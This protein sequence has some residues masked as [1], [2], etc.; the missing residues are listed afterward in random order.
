MKKITLFICLFF[1]GISVSAQCISVD[2]YPFGDIPSINDG[3]LQEIATCN[4]A[5][6]YSQIINLIIGN[7]YQFTGTGGAGNY[8]TITD[9]SDNVIASGLSPLTV[10]AINVTTVKFHIF[11]DNTCTTDSDCHTTTI[12]CVSASCVP[13]PPPVND[14]CVN[15]VSLTVDSTFCDGTNTNATNAGATDSMVT[16]AACFN[17]GENDVWFSFTVPSGVATVDIS[18]D[19]TGGTLMDSEI[20]L[21]SGNCGAL[22]ELDCDQDSGTTVLSN[23]FTWNSIISDTAVNVGETYYVRVSGYDAASTGT[24][25]LKVS[26]NQLLSAQDF[27]SEAFKVYP[28]P[29]KNILN[30][31]YTTEISSV[32][33]FNLLG[34]EVLTK[35]LNAAQTQ[36]DMSNLSAGTYVVKVNVDGTVKTIKV[37]KQ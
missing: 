26:T 2:Q 8:L 11:L 14:E 24:F 9:T 5:G 31:S 15:A 21:Y 3:N 29:V 20:A 10:N 18:T 22:N 12:Q 23:G 33:V 1:I 7:D 30:L 27:V 4:Y 36:L 13:P 19:F 16:T 25:C 6:E 28:N 17:Y 35:H 37:I 32:A 34:Q